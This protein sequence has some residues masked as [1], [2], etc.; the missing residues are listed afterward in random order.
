MYFAK[1]DYWVVLSYSVVRNPNVFLGVVFLVI[2][3][4]LYLTA[5]TWVDRSFGL[6]LTAV[7]YL[8]AA[9]LV[10]FFSRKISH[11]VAGRARLSL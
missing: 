9:L 6:L 10:K 8:F 2:F 5:L 4:F 3:F 1:K 11:G 7:L